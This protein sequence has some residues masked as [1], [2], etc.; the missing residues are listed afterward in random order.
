VFSVSKRVFSEF[1]M[2]FSGYEPA[3]YEPAITPGRGIEIVGPAPLGAGPLTGVPRLWGEPPADGGSGGSQ[4]GIV[5][6]IL[7]VD[8]QVPVH[9]SLAQLLAD[10]GHRTLQAVHGADAPAVLVKREVG[11]DRER[12]LGR[13]ADRSW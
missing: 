12:G 2:R 5:A 11:R 4:G 7:I 1:K 9:D 3:I 6:T 8:D 10:A 13:G